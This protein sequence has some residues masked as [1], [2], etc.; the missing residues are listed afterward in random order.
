[1]DYIY[2]FI[3]E[4]GDS[5]WD[6]CVNDDKEA[7]QWMEEMDYV[8]FTRED[9]NNTDYVVGWMYYNDMEDYTEACEYQFNTWEQLDNYW[10]NNNADGHF[11]CDRVDTYKGGVLVGTEM[12]DERISCMNG[13]GL[14]PNPGDNLTV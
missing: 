14:E 12:K 2:N 5:I 9:V 11:S 7:E 10:E 13:W 8:S 3:D 6:C 4:D 1:M